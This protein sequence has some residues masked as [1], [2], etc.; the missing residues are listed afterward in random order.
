[1]N[2]ITDHPQ[3]TR[4]VNR[5]TIIGH[6]FFW[7]QIRLAMTESE[8]VVMLYVL[9]YYCIIFF[10]SDDVSPMIKCINL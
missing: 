6:P 1:M 2:D 3:L 9:M 5:L 10:L 8:Y 4:I 7:L